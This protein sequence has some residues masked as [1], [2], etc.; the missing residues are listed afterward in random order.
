MLD[1]ESNSGDI[2]NFWAV[3]QAFNNAGINV[4]LAYIPRWYWE[5][6]GCPDL[7]SL[8]ENQIQLV[9]SN[10]PN[11]GSGYASDVYYNAGGEAGPGWTSY[12]GATPTCWQFTDQANVAGHVVDCN[13]YNGPNLDALF[14]F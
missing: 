14:T 13:A 6:I 3:V 7:S 9:S 11:V 8:A 5:K 4:S 1:V 2:D 10:Y 12:G